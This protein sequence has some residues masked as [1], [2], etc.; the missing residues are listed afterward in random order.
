MSKL[1]TGLLAAT[2]ALLLGA[3]AQPPTPPAPLQVK[4]LA[5]NDFH[6]NLQPPGEG[7]R[8]RDPQ[9]PAK[10]LTIAAGGAA[11][12]A[13]AVREL[14]AQNPNHV[15]VAAGDLVGASPLLSALFNDEPT[16]ESLSRMGLAISAVGNHE[17]DHGKVELLRKQHG[18]CHPVEGCKGPRPFT[19]AGYHYLAA[20]TW[21]L[22]TGKTLLPAYEIR[23]FEGVPIGFI[24]L[25]LKDTPG[26]V[27]PSGVAGL[28]FDDEA[29]TV[30]RL[31]PELRAQ[32]V[33]AIVVLIHEGGYPSGDYNECPGISGPIVD[34]VKKLDK[35]V[36][37]IISGHTHR[38]YNCRIDGRTVTS[39]DKYGTV[40][41]DIDLSLDRRS[42]DIT[43]IAA[44]NRIVSAERYAADAAQAALIAEYDAL[45][46]PLAKRIV[47]R[48]SETI[49]RSENAAGATAM[50]QLLADAQLAATRAPERGGAQIAL[51]NIG[52][53]RAALNFQGQG[54]VSYGDAFSVQPFYNQLLT[55]SLTPA[56]LRQVLE[57][58]WLNQPK[59]R[60][61]QVSEGFAYQ[62]DAAR[63]V[64]Q[65]VVADS[66]RLNGQP[67][68]EDAL[69]RVTVSAFLA[70]GGDGFAG[71]AEFGVGRERRIGI[72]DIEALVEYL[73]ARPLTRPPALDRVIR[74]N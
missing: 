30:N 62:W 52:G 74:L 35:A 12:L 20:S 15:F 38:A 18:G 63:P 19:G 34:I 44:Q 9:N 65:R 2:L 70:A 42:G 39:A 17:F 72:M 50:G 40:L 64:G 57:Q 16:I 8:I 3:C 33:E 37:L 48:I 26:I 45:A 22:Q 49:S 14:Q 41:T 54:E 55:L 27:T 43:A 10:T 21:D 56:E 66:L 25:T 51:T 68:R 69:Y 28:R 24:G 36:D 13:S 73:Q 29:E 1:K 7:L 58:Q 46:A 47:G 11:H 4:L 60:P 67:L 53:A 32:G 6:G 59:P 31:V 23:R 71:F 61:L 5:I